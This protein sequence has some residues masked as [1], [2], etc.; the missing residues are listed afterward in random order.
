MSLTSVLVRAVGPSTGQVAPGR[1]S[2]RGGAGRRYVA[3]RWKEVVHGPLPLPSIVV[4]R[5]LKTPR[6][7]SQ[8]GFRLP[9]PPDVDLPL[10]NTRLPQGTRDHLGSYSLSNR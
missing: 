1:T 5:V 6:G 9:S 2:R 3:R 7:F 8:T 4:P 10:S